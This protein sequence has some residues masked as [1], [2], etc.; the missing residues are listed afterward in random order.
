[1]IRDGVLASVLIKK[2]LRNEISVVINAIFM[3]AIETD[4]ERVRIINENLELSAGN[5]QFRKI[6]I[7]YMRPSQAPSE[8]AET[9]IE[10]LPPMLRFLISGLGSARESSEILSYLTFDPLY[11]NALVD[12]GYY[13]VMKQKENLTQFLRT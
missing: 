13:D 12:L 1:M 10:G 3:D 8:L 4:I 2:S 11:L 5:N 9:R 6:D 7:L